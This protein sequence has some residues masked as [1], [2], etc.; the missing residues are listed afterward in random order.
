MI[1]NILDPD[2]FGIP[3]SKIS[4]IS[5]TPI[6]SSVNEFSLNIYN[7]LFPVN[8]NI[9]PLI[10]SL[11]E[12]SPILYNYKTYHCINKTITIKSVNQARMVALNTETSFWTDIDNLLKTSSRGYEIIT[13]TSNTLKTMII[14]NTDGNTDSE[15]VGDVDMQYMMRICDKRMVNSSLDFETVLMEEETNRLVWSFDWGTFE[16]V[17]YLDGQHKNTGK[18]KYQFNINV[19]EDKVMIKSRIEHINKLVKILTMILEKG[20]GLLTETDIEN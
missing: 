11:F 7:S 5:I 16:I 15:C 20:N 9:I 6:T 4:Q 14:G 2:N 13:E 1:E 19:I 3:L 12:K 17:L 18:C 8:E 10:T